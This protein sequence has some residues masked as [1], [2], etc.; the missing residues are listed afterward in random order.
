MGKRGRPAKA[1]ERYACGKLKPTGD[2]VTGALW[3]RI[4][5]H[6]AKLA[7]DERLASEL[8][9]LSFHRQITDAQAAAGF[10]VGLIYGMFERHYSAP[11]RKTRSPSY[12]IGLTGDAGLA[13][14]LMEREAFVDQVRRR[15]ASLEAFL[16]LQDEFDS[17][18]FSRNAASVRPD[19][20]HHGATRRAPRLLIEAVCVDDCTI[21]YLSL[22]HI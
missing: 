12:Q 3:H 19:I 16:A 6:A 18:E 4:R 11:P 1:G 14:E 8:G 17:W 15:R 20:E 21:S 22:I 9:R 5:E 7:R 13:E 10:R 2:P